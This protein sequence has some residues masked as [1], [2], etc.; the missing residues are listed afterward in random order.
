MGMSSLLL[1]RLEHSA[2]L[3]MRCLAHAVQAKGALISGK[4]LDRPKSQR[5]REAI[6]TAQRRRLA[7]HRVLQ[8]I[9]AVHRHA[10]VTRLS[11]EPTLAH[12]Q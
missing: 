1:E 2:A 5:H 10:D 7:A 6:A 8:A 11:S 9:E 3:T 4:L 12:L